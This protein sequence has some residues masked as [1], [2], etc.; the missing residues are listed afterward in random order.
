MNRSWFTVLPVTAAASPWA[1]LTAL[2]YTNVRNLGG[3]MGAWNK[4]GL[5]RKRGQRQMPQAAA[6]APDRCRPGSLHS[7]GRVSL[8]NLPEG[9]LT[10]QSGCF[11]K[12]SPG[13]G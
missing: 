7:P 1:T 3:G 8:P 6:I 9:Y 11:P 12:R 5:K 10:H 4:A 13:F 2:G